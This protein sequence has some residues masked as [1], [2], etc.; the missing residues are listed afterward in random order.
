M[1]KGKFGNVYL[2]KQ[3]KTNFPVALKVL[4]KAP[5]KAANCVATLRREV[6]I[7]CRMKHPNIVRL[8]GYFHD[9]K[10]LYLILE[11]VPN[12]ELFK[13]ISKNG[14]TVDETS[15]LSFMK[16][17]GS[18][19]SYMHKRHVAHRDL[20]P[21]NVLVAKDGRLRVADFGWYQ[22]RLQNTN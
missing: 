22:L 19:V 5:M 10:N 18:A 6:E 14:G 13:T 21:E 8:F 12:G 17:I 15:C 16:D 9:P 3:S 1:G 4:F 11:Y 20:K 7:Q 2:G